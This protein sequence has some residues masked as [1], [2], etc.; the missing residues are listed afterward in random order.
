MSIHKFQRKDVK[1]LYL[2]LNLKEESLPYEEMLIDKNRHHLVVLKRIIQY[3]MQL[4][5]I[6]Q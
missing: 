6:L 4:V 2:N 5:L 1:I 3:P